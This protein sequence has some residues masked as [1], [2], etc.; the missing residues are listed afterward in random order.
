MITFYNR[1]MHKLYMLEQTNPEKFFN[2]GPLERVFSNSFSRVLDFFILN[3]KLDYSFSD[4]SNLANVPP[5]TLQRVL[6]I[7]IKE[8]L[9]VQHRKSG[10]SQMYILNKNSR[11]TKAL[12]FYFNE[13]IDESLEYNE[14]SLKQETKEE[15][16][17]N[18]ST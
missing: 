14:K 18:N 2:E 15:I 6:P 4:I 13:T 12:E 5:R 1:L 7:L 10:K 3:Q 9:V 11:R 16:L 17:P 8:N